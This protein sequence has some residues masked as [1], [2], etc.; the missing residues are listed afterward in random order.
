MKKFTKT[1]SIVLLI[2]MCVSMFT[3]SAF[4]EGTC[5]NCGTGSIVKMDAKAATCTD[6][7]N[8]VYYQC[9]NHGSSCTVF[10]KDDTGSMAARVLS[11]D[12][13]A[14][15]GIP[16]TGH[17]IVAVAEKAANCKEDG[18]TGHYKCETCGKTFVDAAGTTEGTPTV[19]TGGAHVPVAV[20]AVAPDCENDGTLAHRKCSICGTLFA[21]SSDTVITEATILDPATGH[22]FVDGFC[23]DCGAEDPAN[24]QFDVYGDSPVEFNK[25]SVYYYEI[26]DPAVYTL[27][28]VSVDGYPLY[29]GTGY[30]VTTSGK[31]SV[32]GSAIATL[33]GTKASVEVEFHGKKIKGN[34]AAG[35]VGG[36]TINNATT[37]DTLKVD[38]FDQ[39]GFIKGST[40]AVSFQTNDSNPNNVKFYSNKQQIILDSAD[41]DFTQVD[42]DTYTYTL[43]KSFLDSLDC[44]TYQVRCYYSGTKYVTAGTLTI[45]VS[46]PTYDNSLSFSNSTVGKTEFRYVSGGERPE[47]YSP[48]FRD[49]DCELQVSTNGGSSWKDVGV[50]DYYIEQSGGKSTS[51]AWLKS[52]YVDSMPASSNVYF[53]VVIPAADAGTSS[54]V[55]SN[56]VKITTGNTLAAVDT[57]KHVINSSK[58]LKFVCSDVIEK[59]YV[60]G[61]DLSV[62]D[63]DAFRLSNDGK[64]VTLYADFL[65]DRTAGSTYTLS[66]LT[67]SGEKLSTTFQILTTAQASASP[68]TGDDSNIAL[69]SAFLLLSGAAVVAVLPRLKKHF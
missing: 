22:D 28:G 14:T 24:P 56:T 39:K 33:I 26:N 49:S 50:F 62:T 27:S 8:S 61:Q 34:V 65:N 6:A 17:S 29:E 35:T 60:G 3:V 48:L 13:G 7:G 57:N 42:G 19:I 41:F 9:S 15:F 63:P 23:K 55:I 44:G 43:K 52:A 16:A 66:V 21:A 36:F 2:A 12:W 30:N 5:S 53:R 54:D 37:V 1:L 38:G 31:I 68:R 32:N 11:A 18:L 10:Y 46:I 4:A 47:L 25:S 64:Y 69:W 58:N 67:K 51:Y 40:E 45:S 59:V 20:A